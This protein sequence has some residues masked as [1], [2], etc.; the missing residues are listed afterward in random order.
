[1]GE[2]AHE[3]NK[4]FGEF[5]QS[6]CVHSNTNAEHNVTAEIRGRELV[7]RGGKTESGDRVGTEALKAEIQVAGLS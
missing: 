1:M 5:P 6:E 7:E 4:N 2:V 3:H